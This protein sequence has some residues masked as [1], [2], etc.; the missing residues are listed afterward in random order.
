M[1]F[2]IGFYRKSEYF[3]FEIGTFWPVIAP[4]LA[5]YLL[6][7]SSICAFSET[8]SLF[9]FVICGMIVYI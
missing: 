4:M 2:A 3:D 9:I 1:L 7:E 5:K 8:C 6:K